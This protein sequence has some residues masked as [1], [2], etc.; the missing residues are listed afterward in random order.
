MDA[1]VQTRGLGGGATALTLC[2]TNMSNRLFRKEFVQALLSREPGLLD[3]P[4]SSGRT[5]LMLAAA[6]LK[7]FVYQFLFKSANL[8]ACDNEGWTALTLLLESRADPCYV[9]EFL[10]AMRKRYPLIGGVPKKKKKKKGVPNDGQP[11][12]LGANSTDRGVTLHRP[13]FMQR[14]RKRQRK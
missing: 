2:V 3:A 6:P 13:V 8:L 9:D 11:R 14:S 1:G 5:P 4:D 7:Q 12:A 10:S